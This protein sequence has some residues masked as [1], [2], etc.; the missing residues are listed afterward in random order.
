MTNPDFSILIKSMA[1]EIAS[2]LKTELARIASP[3]IQP[4]LLTVKQAAL[5]IGRSEQAVQHLIF[6]KELPVVR[7][8]RR[9]HLDRRDLDAWIEK[10]KY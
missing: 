6:E 2:L 7:K 9:V 1:I 3:Q 10:N 4:V 8:G 5:Y